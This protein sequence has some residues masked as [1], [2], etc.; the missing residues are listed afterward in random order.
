[1]KTN[2]KI[3]SGLAALVLVLASIGSVSADT[4]DTVS[5]GGDFGRGIDSDDEREDGLLASYMEAAIAESLGLS[6]EELNALEDEGKTHFDIALELGFSAE[7]FAAIMDSAQDAA[8]ALAA[9]DGITLQPF[10]MNGKGRGQIGGGSYD[11]AQ[12]YFNNGEDGSYGRGFGQGML[13]A[14]D[15]DE[16][17]CTAEPLGAGMGR[18]RRP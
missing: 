11:E 18:G 15:C 2:T 3:L 7:E 16:E 6:V 1:M 8:M 4:M 12:P 17:T 10:G 14:E 13:N 9:E 5:F